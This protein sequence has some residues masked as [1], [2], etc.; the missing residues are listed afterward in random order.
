MRVLSLLLIM[1]VIYKIRLLHSFNKL[2][3][4]SNIV[5]EKTLLFQILFHLL[6]I[7][8]IRTMLWI[9]GFN[10]LKDTLNEKIMAHSIGL[11]LQHKWLPLLIQNVH[12]FC[13]LEL[14]RKI[15]PINFELETEI[16]RTELLR[17]K[18]RM[19]RLKKLKSIYL[20]MI[21]SILSNLSLI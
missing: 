21:Q 5:N 11:S 2:M 1:T 9:F 20:M 19:S 16:N 14:A 12:Q 10:T 18:R 13:Y 17:N 7:F 3:S 6:I 4:E 8:W 15:A